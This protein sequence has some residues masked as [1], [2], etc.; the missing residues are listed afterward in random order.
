MSVNNANLSSGKGQ[1]AVAQDFAAAQN[2][3]NAANAPAAS[4]ETISSATGVE[5]NNAGMFTNIEGAEERQRTAEHQIIE[6]AKQDQAKAEQLAK[7][8]L[9]TTDPTSPLSKAELKKQEQQAKAEAKKLA[10]EAKKQAKENKRLEKASK[11]N[12]SATPVAQASANQTTAQADSHPKRSILNKLFGGKKK[13]IALVTACLVLVGGG[14]WAWKANNNRCDGL[15][16]LLACGENKISD[17]ARTNSEYTSLDVGDA[18][19]EDV[20]IELNENMNS[21]KTLEEKESFMR[22]YVEALP[23]GAPRDEAIRIYANF[24]I[25]YQHDYVKALEVLDSADQDS[26]CIQYSRQEILALSGQS[27]SSMIAKQC[28]GELY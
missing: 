19:L 7:E 3:Q 2:A 12:T 25:G 21:E 22:S 5:T 16:T 17:K 13:W 23:E 15:M 27:D 1:N 9:A 14:L 8:N 11:T 6:E 26:C 24:I 4:A 20:V 10:K 18:T 28:I